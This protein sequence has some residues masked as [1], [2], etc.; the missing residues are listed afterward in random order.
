MNSPCCLPSSVSITCAEEIGYSVVAQVSFRAGDVVMTCDP[1]HAI[2][3][4]HEVTSRC[5]YCFIKSDEL[6]QC[7]QCHY[8]KYCNPTC[9]QLAWKTGH[10][11]ECKL[12]QRA[13][14]LIQGETIA[15]AR[16]CLIANGSKKYK[17]GE[18]LRDEE[19]GVIRCG[20]AHFQSMSIGPKFVKRESTEMGRIMTRVTSKLSTMECEDILA[21]FSCNNFGICDELLC[22]VGAAIS[23]STAL[24]NHSC[25]PNCVLRYDIK[26]GIPPQIRVR[27]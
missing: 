19:S 24:L 27:I 15:N 6:L 21:K 3:L 10:K 17:S 20:F 12:L 11:A 18:C 8:V 4:D 7:S 5:S 13:Q 26:K 2:L 9:Q 1:Y 23:P 16:L 14:S 22:C 25:R